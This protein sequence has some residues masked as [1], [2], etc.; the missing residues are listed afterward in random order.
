MISVPGTKAARAATTTATQDDADGY[1]SDGTDDGSYQCAD[2][3][4]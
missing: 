1:Q 2:A 4:I 3:V